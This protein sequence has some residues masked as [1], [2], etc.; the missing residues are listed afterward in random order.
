MWEQL[1]ERVLFDAVIDQPFPNDLDGDL[2]DA[3]ALVS[4]VDNQ[5]VDK[6]IERLSK[7]AETLDPGE[8]AFVDT[9][10]EDLDTLLQELDDIENLEIVFLD[11]TK[12]GLR[13]IA[14]HLD[15]REQI[16]AIHILSHGDDG[17]INLGNS[18][19]G[20]DQLESQYGDVL[21]QIGRALSDDGDILIYGCNFG[22]GDAGRE[23]AAALATATGADVAASDDLTGAS[24]LGGD[25]ESGSCAGDDRDASLRD[26]R[27]PRRSGHGHFAFG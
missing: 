26:R 18:V 1:E 16:T 24:K 8:I 25:W 11:P 6:E 19:I 3:G 15:G 20:G 10:V 21:A 23:A 7:G 4:N 12:D 13:Q 5:S 27:L 22:Q 17:E 14:D 2:T 9:A